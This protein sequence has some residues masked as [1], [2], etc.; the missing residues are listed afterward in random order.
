MQLTG[1]APRGDM[2][3]CFTAGG[4]IDHSA[5]SF[6]LGQH[7]GPRISGLS[8]SIGRS[9]TLPGSGN[10]IHTLGNLGYAPADLAGITDYYGL[11]AVDALDLGPALTVTAGF[12]LNV[13]N[14]STRDRSG[15]NAELTGSHGYSHFNPLAGL[16]YQI[17]EG[18]SFFGGYSQANR[19]PTP[20]ETDC[21]SA[22]QPCLLED[23][24]VADPVLKQVVADT[25]EAGLRGCSAEPVT[26]SASLF[27]TDSRNDIV[28]L[29]STIQGRGYFTNVPLTRRQGV[30][31]TGQ[32]QGTSWSTHISY[33][34]LD[35]DYEFTGALASPNNPN[36]DANGNVTVTPGRH[37]PINPANQFRA[38]GDDEILPGLSAG[39]DLVFVG[40]QYYVGDD[41]NQ[42][43]EAARHL[44]ALICAR[45][46]PI[47]C[48]AGKC[49]ASSTIC[50]T[51]T[52]PPMA[53][54]SSRTTPPGLSPRR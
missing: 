11:Y 53:P 31:L 17:I 35:A 44:D 27:R 38:G 37:M 46:V 26:W 19:V 8:T 1:D 3:N 6:L 36:A 4:S 21:A 39:A 41:A 30:D 54:I 29:A 43:R 2:A 47:R 12:R 13:A 51:G 10:I 49:S 25:V 32:Y 34:Y 18:T 9:G 33:S 16:T 20:L 7:P 24:L 23:S 52:M 28:A 50:S 5:I 14:I 48:R 15:L 45:P 40:S 22:T 42:N